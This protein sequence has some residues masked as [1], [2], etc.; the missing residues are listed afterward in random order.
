MLKFYHKVM[1]VS[2]KP[3]AWLLDWRM[4][5][6][7]ED[8]ARLQERMGKTGVPRPEGTLVWLHA[9]SVGEAQSAL[10]LIDAVLKEDEKLHML[11]TTGTLTSAQFL[12]PKLP[13][14]VIHQFYPLDHP[15]WV[16]QF[17]DHW[18]PN[19]ALWM[20]SELW[21]NMLMALQERK[22]PA[23]LV[24][25]RLS[26]K[27]YQKWRLFG[28]IA[29]TLLDTFSLILAQTQ[30]DQAYF[31]DLGAQN[32]TV[33]D[34]LK[35]SA[36][37]LPVSEEDLKKLSAALLGR[38]VWLYASTHEGEEY[39]ACRIHQILRN[40]IPDLLTIIVPRHPDRRDD[41]I[42]TIESHRLSYTVRGAALALPGSEDNV[43]L[44]DT[45]GELG[46][47]YRIA[48]VACIGRSFSR[49]GG[50]GHNPIEAVQLRCGV[51]HG[52]HVQFQQDI[53]NEMDREG[54]ALRL[55]DEA[56]FRQT[57]QKLMTEEE[58]LTEL[59]EKGAA[60]AAGKTAVID[61][62]MEKLMPM[63]KKAG[64]QSA[65]QPSQTGTG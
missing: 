8:A 12:A 19:A 52:P 25:A 10:I 41:I 32:V 59:Q 62:V 5:K 61:R 37:P 45:I 55:S 13:S 46:L 7:K 28:K 44:A 38:P 31:E 15:A 34:N 54:A 50:G 11:V 1:N 21:P 65:A 43:Y 27:S 35:Y 40:K 14:R 18:K 4:K 29:K 16:A 60:Y 53:Y 17:L 22:I 57:L 39:I 47:F 33:T 20:E 23:A 63:L 48:P 64:M 2:H 58:A 56:H 26:G 3:L 30:R 6:G 49:D 42:K 24:N 36:N 51:L 9:A